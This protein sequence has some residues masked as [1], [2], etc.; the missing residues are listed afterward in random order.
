MLQ[1]S[2]AEK[3]ARDDLPKVRSRVRE[4]LVDLP[5]DVRDAAVMTASELVENAMKYGATLPEMNSGALVVDLDQS[6]LTITVENGA[7]PGEPVQSLQRSIDRINSSWNRE[8]LYL[9]RL[10][11]IFDD[12]DAKG[13]LGLL[14][15]AFEGRFDIRCTYAEPIVTITAKRAFQ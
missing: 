7:L 9:A 8:T 10:Q 6:A 3:A 11:E 12:P 13:K 14:R 2:V 4:L 1:F 5:A 15:I